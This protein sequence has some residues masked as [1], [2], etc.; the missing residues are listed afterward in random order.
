VVIYYSSVV[1]SNYSYSMAEALGIAQSLHV[2]A[3]QMII[4]IFFGIRQ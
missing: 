2:K 3:L 4:N 1:F